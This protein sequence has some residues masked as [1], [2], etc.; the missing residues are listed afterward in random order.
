MRTLSEGREISY[1]EPVINTAA[2]AASMASNSR[3]HHQSR[4]REKL[5]HK[6]H[7]HQVESLMRARHLSVSLAHITAENRQCINQSINLI[8]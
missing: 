3:C 7:Y 5:L 2:S 6:Y 1:Y 8:V 4:E